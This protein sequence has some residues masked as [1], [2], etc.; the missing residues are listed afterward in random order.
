MRRLAIDAGAADAVVSNHW[1][2]GGAGAVELGKGRDRGLRKPSDFH[3]LYSLDLSIKDKIEKIVREMY[4]GAGVEYS[5][6]AEKKDGALYT[7]RLRQ[8]ADLHG[9]NAV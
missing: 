3:F 5:P 9:E 8:A 6:E 4:G 2:E 7:A 1:A